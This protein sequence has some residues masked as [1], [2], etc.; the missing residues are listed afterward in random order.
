MQH[1][2]R[3]TAVATLACLLALSAATGAAGRDLLAP[4]PTQAANAARA[5]QPQ[6][7]TGALT[8]TQAAAA[9]QAALRNAQ[10]A[11][12]PIVNT[13]RLQPP[14]FVPSSY[15]PLQTCE[16]STSASQCG[17]GFNAF[18]D[19]NSCCKPGGM[20]K[21][22]C[23]DV[24]GWI[25]RNMTC[26]IPDQFYPRQTCTSTANLTRCM[27]NWQRYRTEADCCSPGAAFPDGCSKPQPCW[28][29]A[30]WYPTR[31]CSLTE[32][33]SICQRGWGAFDTEDACC[34][35]GA[36]FSDGC[37]SAEERAQAAANG[38]ASAAPAAALF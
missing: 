36:G 5:G 3:G 38:T 16:L 31:A 13:R 20:W 27:E 9:Q 34:E 8:P 10:A 4:T 32:D 23:T 37:S 2:A 18:P 1:P 35:A 25:R 11:A 19:Y 28:A 21:N 17:Q 7:Q 6:S 30:A 14:C 29:A 22:G 26:Y 12:R 15:Y 24:D 33:Q